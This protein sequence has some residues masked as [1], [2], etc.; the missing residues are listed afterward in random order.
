MQTQ[1]RYKPINGN[2]YLSDEIQKQID[3]DLE[4]I[5]DFTVKLETL[6]K[7][8]LNYERLKNKVL[9]TQGDI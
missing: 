9:T 4:L 1:I 5:K 6:K 7:R 8:V 3:T 2:K